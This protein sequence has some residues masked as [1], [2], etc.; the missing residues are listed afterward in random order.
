M[1]DG[2]GGGGWLEQRKATD[3]RH[4][5]LTWS[6]LVDKREKMVVATAAVDA[7]VRRKDLSK[8]EISLRFGFS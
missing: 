6:S 5:I 4:Q 8:N 3:G 1:M 7:A 2:G